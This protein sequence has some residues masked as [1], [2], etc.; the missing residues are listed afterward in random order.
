MSD[1]PTDTKVP[2]NLPEKPVAKPKPKKKAVAKDDFGDPGLTA[3]GLEPIGFSERTRPAWRHLTDVLGLVLS[4]SQLAILI[5]LLPLVDATKPALLGVLFGLL[6][7]AF[8]AV[9][10]ATPL[11]RY[12]VS[13]GVLARAAYG[14]RG[15]KILPFVRVILG[16]GFFAQAAVIAMLSLTWCALCVS[17]AVVPLYQRVPLL[18]SLSLVVVIGAM[19]LGIAAWAYARETKTTTAIALLVPAVLLAAA[20]FLLPG[21]LPFSTAWGMVD[22][23]DRA[24]TSNIVPI[25]V[26]AAF[27][28]ASVYLLN[29]NEARRVPTQLGQ[30]LS[31]LGSVV[32]WLVGSMGYALA[33]LSSGKSD[34]GFFDLPALACRRLSAPWLILVL[35]CST[36]ALVWPLAVACKRSV[37]LGL[38][39]LVASPKLRRGAEYGVLG[40]A[41]L[42]AVLMRG[43]LL[44]Y[45]YETLLALSW[46]HIVLVGCILA[47]Y[48]LVERARLV[49][50]DLYTYR[51]RYRG[52][53]GLSPAGFVSLAIACGSVVWAKQQ[54]YHTSLAA[55]LGF[56]TAILIYV[57]LASIQRLIQ[58]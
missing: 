45:G 48:F 52:V 57:V 15:A 50:D 17:P 32:P 10:T 20:L 29:V 8:F 22:L 34:N 1:E 55:A 53:F 43:G 46:F 54:G 18:G 56:G 37:Q 39:Q 13:L 11:L 27:W 9:L 58:R 33:V 49:L 41:L 19:I 14:V 21:N 47:H 12:G 40:L 28:S 26:G 44:R 35:A 4:P 42:L 51:G 23:I 3:K 38:L 24:Q 6:I 7:G 5:T 30:S 2:E 36:V 16:V 25:L 31:L